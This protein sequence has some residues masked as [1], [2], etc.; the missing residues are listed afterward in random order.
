M[1]YRHKDICNKINKTYERDLNKIVLKA[2]SKRLKDLGIVKYIDTVNAIYEK[3]SG[4][5]EKIRKLKLEKNK[6]E[7]SFKILYGKK[8]EQK[9]TEEKFKEEYTIYQNKKKD[10]SERL[11]KLELEY[12]SKLSKKELEKII[13]EYEKCK[14]FTN[15][16]VK[17]LVE[18]IEIG[19]ENRVNIKLKF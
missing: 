9:I 16:I 1:H 18:R 3:G 2:I 4:E 8:I 17:S 19:D 15:K 13:Q 5:N 6:L 12:S 10:I 14:N 11:E 7:N